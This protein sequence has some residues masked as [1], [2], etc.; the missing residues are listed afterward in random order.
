MTQI[1]LGK[2]RTHGAETLRQWRVVKEAENEQAP[3]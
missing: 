3:L 1:M 2:R